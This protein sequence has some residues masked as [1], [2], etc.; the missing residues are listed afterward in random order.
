MGI[1]LSVIS[2]P[3]LLFFL[4]SEERITVLAS[5][6]LQGPG[7]QDK[8]TPNQQTNCETYLLDATPTRESANER[9]IVQVGRWL[10]GPT[11]QSQGPTGCCDQHHRQSWET[12]STCPGRT[13]SNGR[14]VLASAA[15]AVLAHFLAHPAFPF[16]LRSTCDVM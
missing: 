5:V 12:P 11:G 7:R 8:T 10:S 13:A 1:L 15:S 14:Q 16:P 6:V 9:C 4:N 2:S 3:L